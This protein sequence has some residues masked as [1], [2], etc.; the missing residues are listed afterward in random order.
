[1]TPIL[2]VMGG[3][4]AFSAFSGTITTNID[5]KAAT[6]SFTQTL[7]FNGTNAMNGPLTAYTDQGLS[8][9][10]LTS[11][12]PN[13]TLSS[14]AG[15]TGQNV[16]ITLSV[17]NFSPA[18]WAKFVVG[19]TNT[20]T[21]AVALNTS[22]NDFVLNA[23]PLS[24]VYNGT[25]FASTP[26]QIPY[27]LIAPPMTLSGFTSLMTVQPYSGNWTFAFGSVGRQTVPQY[28]LPQQTFYFSIYVGLGNNAPNSFQGQ[29][30]TLNFIMPMNSVP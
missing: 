16:E 18:V 26:A 3:A 14:V 15:L 10:S 22:G 23:T 30:L 7:Y 27:S 8:Q 11:A 21:A 19:I 12:T 2:V 1:M 6:L 25:G 9:I 5:A 29:T 24:Y 17:S 28:L 20:G 4:L 13:Q